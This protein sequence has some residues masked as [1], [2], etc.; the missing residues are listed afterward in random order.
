M[1]EARASRTAY[2]VAMR[3][4]AHQ[5]FDKP[6]ILDDPIALPIL[7]AD[8]EN[9][10]R[11]EPRFVSRF[12]RLVRASMAA[13]SR[14]AED[15]LAMAVERGARQYVILGAGLDTFAY[16]NPHEEIGLRVFEVDHPATQGW[17]KERLQAARIAIPQSLTFV[18]VDFEHQTL[19]EALREAGFDAAQPAFF[20]WLGVT[21]Y[22]ERATVLSTLRFIASCGS[23]A[24]AARGGVA[25]DYIVPRASLSWMRRFVFDAMARRVEKAGEPFR[26]FFTP[27]D[28]TREL[29]RMGFQS[30]ENI[31]G[32]EINARYFSGRTDGLRVPGILGRFASARM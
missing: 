28:L 29:E 4:A 31:G 23:G 5:L 11:N 32:A 17:K 26:T 7:G 1:I 16:R 12:G 15:Q 24:C 3:R 13:R 18:P 22:L 9:R 8:A 21:M 6:K 20:S 25:F 27:Q 30:I 14:Y 19:A 2:M 10:L